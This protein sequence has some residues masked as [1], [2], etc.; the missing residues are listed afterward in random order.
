[1]RA[2]VIVLGYNGRRY[3]EASLASLLDQD[4]PSGQ[5]EVLYVDNDSWD[6]SADFV[7]ARF[8]SVNVLRLDRN[9]GFY[10]AFNLAVG[11]AAGTY[12]V[13]VPQD[14]VAHRRWLA[15]LVAVA[16]SDERV[17]VAVT[18]TIGP[19]S[20]DYHPGSRDANVSECTWV[21]LSRLGFVRLDRGP[22]AP[23]PRQTLACAGCSALLRR[24]LVERSG[25]LFET[26]VGHYGGDV[27]VGLRASV[28]GGKVMQ[29]P[30]S[31]IYHV[32]EESKTTMDARLLLRYAEGSRD[33]V[34]IFY[35]LMTTAEFI[36][37]LPLMLAGLSMKTTVL[38]A[39]APL[40]GL[41]F[42]CALALSP[43]VLLAAVA[44]M[45]RLREARRELQERRRVERFW[46]PRAI[47]GG[48]SD[49]TAPTDRM[50]PTDL[51]GQR[52]SGIQTVAGRG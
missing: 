37:F 24:E 15:E 17:L 5:F 46:R 47:V 8:P 48:L 34:L 42:C 50:S 6:G 4:M 27:E 13:A 22:F 2:S 31:V 23:A 11:R 21:G 9:L 32:G 38:R 36:L 7:A 51:E 16:D 52:A 45:P 18:N 30:T 39:S 33:Q 35:K 43:L 40:R 41:L 28:V 14:V 25:C 19:G 29:V 1:M 3:L 12:L 20:P 44:R 49:W 26:R 10:G